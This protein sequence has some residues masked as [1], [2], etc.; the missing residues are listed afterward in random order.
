M[1]WKCFSLAVLAFGLAA[2]LAAPGARADQIHT[3]AA[4]PGAVVCVGTESDPARYGAALADA[5][6]KVALY[7]PTRESDRTIIDTYQ[8]SLSAQTGAARAR[9]DRA[10]LSDFQPPAAVDGNDADCGAVTVRHADDGLSLDARRALR[11]LGMNGDP[12]H[13]AAPRHLRA[14]SARLIRADDDGALTAAALCPQGVQACLTNAGVQ[15][16]QACCA[17]HPDGHAC[18]PDQTAR[19]CRAEFER[20][21]HRYASLFS[22]AGAQASSCAPSGTLLPEADV[23]ACC[24]GRYRTLTE[25][26]AVIA[27]AALDAFEIGDPF[28]WDAIFL[29]DL[30]GD[31][32]VFT[33]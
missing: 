11:R 23:A 13:T 4:E 14:L 33:P 17:R 25:G 27:M 32:I 21:A 10:G 31:R 3:Y 24:E 28:D 6:G 5:S 20:A 12:Y 2:P 15:A 22:W 8:V 29:C 19:L 30:E 16:H 1:I 7:F 18:R 9:E 26:E